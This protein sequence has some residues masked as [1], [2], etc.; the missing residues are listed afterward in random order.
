MKKIQ[1]LNLMENPVKLST[2][3]ILAKC[4]QRAP[5]Y[6]NINFATPPAVIMGRIK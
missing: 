4:G 3:I 2:Q 1:G 5:M 6:Q